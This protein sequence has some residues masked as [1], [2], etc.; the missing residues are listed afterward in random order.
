MP[1]PEKDPKKDLKKDQQK[2]LEKDL[3]KDP[4]KDLEKDLARPQPQLLSPNPEDIQTHQIRR[5]KNRKLYDMTRSDYINLT[6]VAQLIW[7]WHQIKVVDASDNRDRTGLTLAQ[8]LLL[9]ITA[10]PE[11]AEK[12]QPLL[13]QAVLLMRPTNVPSD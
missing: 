11:A 5:Y 10:H 6:E 1:S 8:V 3:E 4:E 2:D 12:L 13:Y 9:E 7:Q